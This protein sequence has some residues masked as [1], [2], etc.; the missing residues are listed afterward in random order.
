MKLSQSNKTIVLISV[1]KNI[2]LFIIYALCLLSTQGAKAQSNCTLSMQSQPQT[3]LS[4]QLLATLTQAGVKADSAAVSLYGEMCFNGQTQKVEKFTAQATNFDIRLPVNNLTDTATLGQTTAQALAILQK[5]SPQPR[6]DKVTI[7]YA[8]G[9]ATNALQSTITQT[10]QAMQQNL[11]GAALMQTL[12]YQAALAPTVIQIQPT[13]LNLP[14]CANTAKST[15]K[16]SNV[17]G[18]FSFE[19]QLAFDPKL[20]QVVDANADQSG[21]QVALAS[22]LSGGFIV[23]NQVDNSV[24]RIVVAISVL[25]LSGD[26]VLFDINWQAKSAGMTTLTFLK[27]DLVNG[28]EQ[29]MSHTKQNGQ[30]KLSGVCSQ[31]S[32]QVMLQ[33]RQV[34]QGITI[35]DGLGQKTETDGQGNFNFYGGVSVSA[36]YAGYL[37]ALANIPANTTGQVSVGRITLLAGDI[38]GDDI[39]NIFDLS[40]M[41]TKFNSDDVTTDAN[42][43]GVVNIFDLSLAATN[44]GQRGPLKGWAQ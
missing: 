17:A 28:Q 21:V 30:I 25:N 42:G 24:G 10:T 20:V 13:D 26:A 27:T 8:V 29:P 37:T 23:S 33:G 18:L 40:A 1:R 39:I 6:A 22:G 9:E 19:I 44:Y 11:T 12:G 38:N 16:V 7:T 4:G 2:A 15:V 14:L 35:N 43:D 3:E 32:G 5:L 34:Y 36:K 31:I 41:S